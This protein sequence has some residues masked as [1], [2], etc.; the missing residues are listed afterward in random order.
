MPCFVPTYGM[1]G[2]YV[3]KATRRTMSTKRNHILKY[4]DRKKISVRGDDAAWIEELHHATG[5]SRTE[6]VH[7][8]VAYGGEHVTRA[9]MEALRN[10][11]AAK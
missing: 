3:I 10:H 1:I 2:A 11:R 5:A 6:I 9:I 7:R 8:L 4:T